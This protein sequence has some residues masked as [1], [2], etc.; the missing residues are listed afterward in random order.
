LSSDPPSTTSGNVSCKTDCTFDDPTWPE[1]D[2]G[3]KEG[4]GRIAT[5]LHWSAWHPSAVAILDKFDHTS[6][7]PLSRFK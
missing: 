6:P 4:S 1:V 5:W 2:E 7:H 3:R